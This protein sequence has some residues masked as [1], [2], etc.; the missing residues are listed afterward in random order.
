MNRKELLTVVP[1]AILTL[2]AGVYPKPLFDI[3][4]PSLLAVLEGAA[5]VVGN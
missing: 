1:L 4:E 3:M 2:V 5:R